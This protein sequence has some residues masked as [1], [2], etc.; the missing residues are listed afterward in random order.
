MKTK[1]KQIKENEPK[2]F[3]QLK[4]KKESTN[5]SDFLRGGKPNL[6]CGWCGHNNPEG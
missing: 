6:G 1:S 4:W 5:V 3:V 2:K